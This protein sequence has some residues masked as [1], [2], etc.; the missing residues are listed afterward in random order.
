MASAVAPFV[1]DRRSSQ[2]YPIDAALRY[3]FVLN[4]KAVTGTGGT[5]NLSSDGVLFRTANPLPKG[6]R[7][8]LSIAWP[9]RLDNLV[10]LNLHVTGET[11]R[12]EGSFTAVIFR[13]HE[14]RTQGMRPDS[15]QAV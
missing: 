15:R 2:R 13:R 9:A 1:K 6:V 14:F 10:G 8:E 5:V 7:I 12:T 3:R 4:R 11:V